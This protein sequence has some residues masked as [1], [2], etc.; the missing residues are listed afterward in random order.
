MRILILEDNG[1]RVKKFFEMFEEYSLV[2]VNSAADA[3]S[4]ASTSKFD[5]IFLDHDLGGKVYVNSED[6]NTGYQV[7]KMLSVS[8]NHRTPVVIHSWNPD[9]AKK[10]KEAL[11]DHNA[12]VEIVPFETFGSEILGK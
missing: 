10:M 11:R 1:D 8:I 9:G 5:A 7:A 12:Q 3:I 4:F 2:V 6:E